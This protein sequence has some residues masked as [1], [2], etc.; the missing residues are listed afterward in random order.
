MDMAYKVV[1]GMGYVIVERNTKASLR[2]GKIAMNGNNKNRSYLRKL[3][4]EGY[5]SFGSGNDAPEIE[6][7]DINILIGAN[8]SG[9]SNFISFFTM[10]SNMM[11][12]GLQNYIAVN[13]TSEVMLHF[14][15]RTTPM[16]QASLEFR[17]EGNTDVY[18]F[19]LARSVRDTL[20][21][22]SEEIKWNGHIIPLSSGRSE[23]FFSSGEVIEEYQRVI[24]HIL[25]SCR[26]YQFHDTSPKSN[27]RKNARIDNN[28]FLYSDA[29]NLAAYLYM[30]KNKSEDTRKYYGRIIGRIRNVV[31]GIDDFILE[32]Q[33]LN[34]DYIRLN[35]TEKNRGDYVFGPDQ[36]SDGS[37]R[38]MALATLFLQPPE[39]LPNL[40]IIDEP[41]IGLHPQAIDALAMMIRIASENCQ[42]IVATQSARLLD[43]FE[44]E[45][46]IVAEKDEERNVSRF[47][48][49]EREKLEEW[50]KDYSLS[51]L[52]EKNVIGGQP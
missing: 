17:N 27:I 24:R 36:I 19:G 26:A 20:V 42:V 28:R 2:D 16:I 39:M 44:P 33:A 48:R 32:P 45:D 6:L 14:G 37:L 1:K 12:G 5:K 3:R 47:H 9:K 15:S 25:R 8:G 52:W 31:P 13:G 29:G 10:L 21:I 30:L 40:I 4:I 46:I 38:F 49:L 11:T 7:R 18:L 22:T 35:W 50:L 41:E 43:S 34:E 51:Q 23:S